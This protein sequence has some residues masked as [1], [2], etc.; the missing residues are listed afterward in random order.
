MK[1]PCER[2]V[3]ES[4]PSK[5]RGPIPARSAHLP[6]K[7]TASFSNFVLDDVRRAV[8]REC[9]LHIW[10]R[11]NVTGRSCWLRSTRGSS[12]PL[13][14]K[15][16]AHRCAPLFEVVDLS[17]EKGDTDI[18]GLDFRDQPASHLFAGLR[19]CANYRCCAF[20]HNF[21]DAPF[22]ERSAQ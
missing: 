18:G 3:D 12:W 19:F 11:F 21:P 22:Q 5:V 13:I 9:W 4:L 15:A 16:T 10:F 7:R 8:L 14:I 1:L 17:A 6:E 2:G 20:L